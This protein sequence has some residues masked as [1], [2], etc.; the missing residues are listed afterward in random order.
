MRISTI[1]QPLERWQPHDRAQILATHTQ[2]SEVE[3]WA[4]VEC[5]V[6][7]V[8][9][10]Y[11]DQLERNGHANRITDLDLF[12]SL[13][14]TAIRYPLLWERIAPA[15]LDRADWLWADQRLQR[16]RDLDIDPI[17]GLVHHGSGPDHTSLIEPD[18]P[19]KLAEFAKAVATRYPWVSHYTPI[20]EPL[21]TARFSGLYGHW[22]PHGHDPATFACALMNQCRAIVLSMQAIRQINPQAKLIQTEDLGKV[23]ST[24]SLTY[25]AD[26][27]NERRWLSFDL[28]CGRLDRAHPL[29]GYLGELGISDSDL[30]WFLDNSCPPDVLGINHYLT[31]DRFL[32]ERLDRYPAQL[33]GGNGRHAYAD[34]EAVR[35]RA[36]GIFG[37][38]N[39]LQEVWNRYGRSMALTEVHLGCTREEQLRWLNEAWT[40]ANRLRKS[41]AD[42]RAVTAWSLLGAY[43]WNT[44]LTRSE[45]FYEPGVFDLRSPTPRPTALAHMLRHLANGQDYAHPILQE[46][47]WWRRSQRLVYPSVAATDAPSVSSQHESPPQKVSAPIVITGATGTLGRAFARLCEMRG[48]PYR[49]LTRQ[50]MDIT[51]SRSVTQVLA[52]LKPWAVINTAA[53]V[54]VDDAEQHPHLCRQINADGAAILAEACAEQD[55]S[56]VTFSSDLVFDGNQTE[57]Y[58]ES[59]E[60]APLNVYGHSKA[61]AEQWVLATNPRALVIRTSAFFGPWDDHNFLTIALRTLASGQPFFAADDTVISP[62]YVPDLVNATLDLLIDQECGLWHLANLGAVSWAEFAQETA[63]LAG[64]NPSHVEACSTRSLKLAAPRPTYTA[65]TSERG[66]LLPSLDRAIGHY[67]QACG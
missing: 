39:L 35:V 49:L 1:S 56:F 51:D 57:P 19:E 64:F 40:A 43:D 42:V 20:N 44:L 47:G 62:T 37:H 16:L 28:L 45:G 36:D 12:A 9:N 17:V 54:R 48:I 15:S 52:D 29:W 7:R 67:L 25:Q 65:L 30:S 58:V 10:D 3:L 53:Y 23:F 31:S 14:V 50:D 13:G 66:I 27:E 5:T 2:K 8:G 24:P 59:H 32:D 4:G 6:N 26:F 41:G 63:R 22:Y 11:F 33:H 38:H 60:V 34:V 55:I 21:T 18:F 46:P 61:I